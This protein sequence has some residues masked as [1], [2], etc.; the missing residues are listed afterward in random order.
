MGNYTRREY[1][2]RGFRYRNVTGRAEPLI[3][4]ELE[5]EHQHGYH[6]VL[7]ALPD[8][9]NPA[10]R[11][12]TE[13]DGS[14]NYSTG[15]EIVFPPMTPAQL[16]NGN[17]FI[18]R[19]FKALEQA[20]VESDPAYCGMH[21]NINTHGWDARTRHAY[22]AMFFVMDKDL[23]RAIGGRY[24]TEYCE[25]YAEWGNRRNISDL[26][27][28]ASNNHSVVV[29][30]RMGRVE[31][32]FPA[33]TT[34][35][36]NL[37]RVVAFSNFVKEY[38]ETISAV[39]RRTGTIPITY[40]PVVEWPTN[41]PVVTTNNY[42]WTECFLSDA[43]RTQVTQDLLTMIKNSK[44]SRSKDLVMKALPETTKRRYGLNARTHRSTSAAPA[45]GQ[46]NGGTTNVRGQGT[47]CP[48]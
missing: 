8:T 3:G 1:H 42:Y 48:A 5:V 34:R 16:N 9:R 12:S 15:V 41:E 29:S 11:P 22:I 25:Q 43:F 30:A 36:E 18:R 47:A 10:L 31:L 38:V 13:T 14:L 45:L 35:M 2:T 44:P 23:I 20:G 6:H 19:S 4:V 21:V 33:S 28:Y 7:E 46:R 37:Q 40:L 32:R 24:E 27:A 26:A 39:S 17:S